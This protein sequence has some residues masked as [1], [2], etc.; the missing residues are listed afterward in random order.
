MG[1]EMCIRDSSKIIIDTK[2]RN[3]RVVVSI[4]DNG[5]G[6]PKEVKPHVFDMFYSGANQIADSRRSLG[7]GLSLCKTIIH[8]HGGEIQVMDNKPKGTVFRFTL[9]AGEVKLYE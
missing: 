9:P 4:S 3:G 8:A 7:L 2:K 5:P 1:S 6:I